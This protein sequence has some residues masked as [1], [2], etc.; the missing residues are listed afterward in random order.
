MK[1][2]ETSSFS[3]FP[4]AALAAIVGLVAAVAL[5][6]AAC[7]SSSSAPGAAAAQE[8]HVNSDCQSGLICALG[9]CRAQCTTSADCQTGGT[10]IDNG[11]VAVCQYASVTPCTKESDCPAPLACASDYRCRNLC[12][13]AADCNVL[14]ITGRLCA[15]DMNG[16]DFCADP[17]EVTSG[18][19][20]ASPP[21]SAPTA[22]SVVE[23]DGG[24]S[25]LM[26]PPG[27]L[28]TTSIGQAGGTLGAMGVTVTIPAGALSSELPI[29]IELSAQPGP[30]GTISRVF[31]IG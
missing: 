25:A 13:S 28:I 22:T 17:S 26:T 23:P 16:V 1:G 20:T 14:G 30:T 27:A 29:T 31:D 21:P 18:V 9:E 4:F 2:P 6:A 19:I 5:G 12:A 24:A 8:C 7:N 3:K 11:D 10:C 15:K